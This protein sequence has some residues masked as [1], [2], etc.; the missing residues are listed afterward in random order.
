MRGHLFG[1]SPME[2]AHIFSNSPIG[3]TFGTIFL[4]PAKAHFLRVSGKIKTRKNL[5]NMF[6]GEALFWQ[7]AYGGYLFLAGPSPPPINN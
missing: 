5:T 7:V 4:N 1:K 3:G 6:V 2:G